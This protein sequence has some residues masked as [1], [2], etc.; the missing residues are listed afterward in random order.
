MCINHPARSET[1]WKDTLRGMS[2]FNTMLGFEAQFN[3]AQFFR[4][5]PRYFSEGV[6]TVIVSSFLLSK[7]RKRA[8]LAQ[9]RRPNLACAKL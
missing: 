9:S 4:R 3:C 7:K 5:I 8:S 6:Y 1:P 2:A